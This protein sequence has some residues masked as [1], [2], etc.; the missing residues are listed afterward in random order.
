MTGNN[1]YPVLSFVAT[2]FPEEFNDILGLETPPII[3]SKN[4]V[5]ESIQKFRNESGNKDLVSR[6]LTPSGYE[7]TYHDNDRTIVANEQLNASYEEKT[8]TK[9]VY[10]KKI[11]NQNSEEY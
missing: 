11:F 10:E 6:Y 1:E 2:K 9:E 3:Q 8:I 4:P 5:Y 7:Y